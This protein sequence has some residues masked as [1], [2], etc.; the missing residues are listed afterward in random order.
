MISYIKGELTE[1]L[2]GIVVLESGQMG[3]EIRVPG[4][5]LSMLP[6]AGT[7][8]KLYT[9][10]QVREDAVNLFGFLTRDDLDIF[11]LLLGVNGV[12]PRAA[13]GILSILSADD[14]RFAVLSG[15]VKAISRA[16]GIGN[17]TA[18]KLILELKDKLKLE[19]AFAKKQENLQRNIASPALGG[20]VKQE[21]VL[22]L[23]ALGYSNSEALKAVSKITITE[24]SQVEEVLKAA[25]KHMAF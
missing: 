4:S 8:M 17:K 15:D 13:L 5:I 6:P 3:F 25:L 23:T 1:V 21:A 18:Q 11:K 10:M 14:L 7:Q 9:Y 12:G 16:P 20:N 2:T 24:D 22:A 19:D